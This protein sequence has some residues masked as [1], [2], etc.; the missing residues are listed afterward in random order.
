MDGGKPK[1]SSSSARETSFK[2]QAINERE[3]KSDRK[4]SA[5]AEFLKGKERHSKHHNKQL[6]HHNNQ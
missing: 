4:S 3:Y 6:K 2:K 5:N 1:P